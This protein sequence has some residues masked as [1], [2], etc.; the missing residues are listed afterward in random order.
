M[1]YGFWEVD[2][3]R[4][5]GNLGSFLAGDTPKSP[6]R[7]VVRLT[8]LLSQRVEYGVVG[9]LTQLDALLAKLGVSP[10]ECRERSC[11]NLFTLHS[12]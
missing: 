4:G 8:I 6:S 7:H 5:T 11:H 3:A 12:Q 1:R 9:G 2:P 10:K